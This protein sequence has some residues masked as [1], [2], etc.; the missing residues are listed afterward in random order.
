MNRR[1]QALTLAVLLMC[2]MLATA[3]QPPGY[4]WGYDATVRAARREGV[5][6][7]YGTTDTSVARHLVQDFM[8]LYPGLTVDYRE[9]DSVEIYQRVLREAAAGEPSADVVWSSA[10]DLQVKL[11][12]DGHGMRYVSPETPSLPAWAVWKAEAYGTTFEPIGFAYNA[13]LLRDSEVPR[14]HGE[15]I[16]LLRTHGN[17]FKGR[18][19]TYDIEHS[20]LGFLFASQDVKASPMLWDVARVLG[21]NDAR[22]E[23]S[24]AAM[25]ESLESGKSVI[26]YNVLGSYAQGRSHENSSVGFVYPRDYTLVGSRIAFINRRASHPY[27]AKLWLDHLLSKRGQTVMAHHSD[28]FALRTDLESGQTAAA[29]THTLGS[30]LRPIAIGPSLMVYLDRSKRK[31]FLQDWKRA[32]GPSKD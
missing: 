32:W 7:V 24:T 1:V 15:L 9:F 11:V 25:L 13:R 29:L 5:V 4:P 28:L 31:S 21:R 30:S 17:R 14:T 27:A 8:V 12:N 19:T 10:M 20:G 16:R 3:Q 18:V 2:S 22:L 23:T 26:A 6:V